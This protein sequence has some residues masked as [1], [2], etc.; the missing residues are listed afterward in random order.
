MNI[1]SLISI[2]FS[3]NNK[4]FVF[5]IPA[6]SQFSECYEIVD[7]LLV[8]LKKMEEQQKAQ[9]EAQ[10]QSQPSDPVTPELV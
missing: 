3:K 1:K 4:D 9:A 6:G 8:E 2:E 10:N 7:E 5:H